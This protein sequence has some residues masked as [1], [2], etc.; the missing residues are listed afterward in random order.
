MMDE[1]DDLREERALMQ[2]SGRSKYFS[3]TIGV[4]LSIQYADESDPRVAD[5][6]SKSPSA[7]GSPTAT[8]LVPASGARTSGVKILQHGSAARNMSI[9]L[10]TVSTHRVLSDGRIMVPK[11]DNLGDL[12]EPIEWIEGDSVDRFDGDTVVIQN[13]PVGF[14]GQ[15]TSVII[16]SIPKG[17][18]AIERLHMSPFSRNSSE[19]ADTLGEYS[20]VEEELNIISSVRSTNPS[21]DTVRHPNLTVSESSALP[22]KAADQSLASYIEASYS[23]GIYDRTQANPVGA[24]RYVAHN[25]TIARIDQQGNVIID[26]SLAGIQNSDIDAVQAAVTGDAGH[27]DVNIMRRSGQGLNVRIGGEVVFR[28]A[29]DPSG[30]SITL[31]KELGQAFSA[32]L[33]ERLQ[34]VFDNHQ[35][36]TAQGPTTIPLPVQDPLTAGQF[37]NEPVPA[38]KSSNIKTANKTD[39]RVFASDIIL[40]ED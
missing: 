19:I 8:V 15:F 6:G 30:C 26:T 16:G 18:P 35:H 2:G 31:G 4:V 29:A 17:K 5:N 28:I 21:A 34:E 38:L 37:A 9:W 22:D 14:G 27:I 40:K 7:Y 39:N 24:E 13:L 25:G 1:I 23:T 3:S 36:M 33:G 11:V 32:V 10:P 20:P 12:V